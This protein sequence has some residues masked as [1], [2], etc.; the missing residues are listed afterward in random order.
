MVAEDSVEQIV[1]AALRAGSGFGLRF[2]GTAA[3]GAEPGSLCKAMDP[4]K[5]KSGFDIWPG[6]M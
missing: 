2:H 3:L 1:I 4:V 5:L 6:I